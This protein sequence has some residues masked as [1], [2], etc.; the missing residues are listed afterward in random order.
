MDACFPCFGSRSKARDSEREPLLPKH[1]P[2]TDSEPTTSAAPNGTRAPQVPDAGDS[3]VINKVVEVLAALNAGKLPTQE[4]TTHLLQVLLGS[5]LLKEDNST[6]VVPGNGPTS[7]QG[8]KVLKDVRGLIQAMLQFGME[9][10]AD[11]KLQ[12]LYFQFLSLDQPPVSVSVHVDAGESVGK[13]QKAGEAA[14]DNSARAAAELKREAPTKNELA[15]DATTLFHA[16]RTIFETCLSSSVFRLVLS[17]II[18]I[19]RDLVAH[20]AAD[21]QRAAVEVQQVAED[22]EQN[23]LDQNAGDVTG[24]DKNGRSKMDIVSDAVNDVKEKG[25]EAAHKIKDTTKKE[26]NDVGND[27][28]DRT[29]ERMLERIR[30]TI[31]RIQQDPASRLAMRSILTLARKYAEKIASASETVSS[32]VEDTIEDAK[33]AATSESGATQEPNYPPHPYGHNSAS[34]SSTGEKKPF[35]DFQSDAILQDLKDILERIAKGHSLD[36][37]FDAFGRIVRGLNEMPT[38][39][40]KDVEK[41]TNPMTRSASSLISESGSD[42]HNQVP[43]PL[44]GKDPKSASGQEQGHKKRKNGKARKRQK[45]HEMKSSTSGL[46]PPSPISASNSQDST[47]TAST[48]K[49]EDKEREERLYSEENPLRTY[50]KRLG[51]YLDRAIEEKDW[52]ISKDGEQALESL[53][54][55]GAE[56]VNVVGDSVVQVED[57]M[58]SK[59]AE[60]EKKAVHEEPGS[61]EDKIKRQFKKDLSAF[62]DEAEAYIS[63]MENDKTTMKL[64]HAFENLGVDLRALVSKGAQQSKKSLMQ[65]LMDM[66]SWTNWVG[67]AI[68]RVLRMLPLSAIPIPSIEFKTPEVEGALQAIFVQGLAKGSER[69][70]E[71]MQY[72]SSN[73]VATSLVPDEVVLKQWTELRIDMVDYD[74]PL[75]GR[76]VGSA[77]SSSAVNASASGPAGPGVQTTSRFRM[78]LDGVRARVEGMGYYFKYKGDYLGYEDEG[79]ASV[80]LGMGQVHN[81]FAVDVEIEMSHENVAFAEQHGDADAGD[82]QQKRT[83]DTLVVEAEREVDLEANLPANLDVQTLLQRR[84]TGLGH[85]R[86]AIRDAVDAA[87]QPAPLFSV[88]D[89]DVEMRGLHFQFDKSRHWIL[90]KLFVQ[91]LAGPVVARV[92]KHAME[93]KI[94][95]SLE[96]LAVGLGEM[97]RDAARRAEKREKTSSPS[98]AEEGLSEILR[99]W[100][101]AML[102]VGPTLFGRS[103]VGGEEEEDERVEVVTRSNVQSTSKGLIYKNVTT[104]KTAEEVEPSGIPA[105]YFNPTTNTMEPVSLTMEDVDAEYQAPRVEVEEEETVVAVGGGAQLFPGKA[106]AYGVDH[107]ETDERTRLLDTVKQTAR[108][109]V[110]EAKD[111]VKRGVDVVEEAGKRWEERN[112]MEVKDNKKT[113]RSDAFNF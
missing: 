21:V 59:A 57:E 77:P 53:F 50:F 36:G 83:D 111:G 39:V 68:P 23:A 94:R 55:D 78:H 96:D 49:D 29:K 85:A 24:E 108:E 16:L 95:E 73:P 6:N 113:W 37:L 63:A 4:Q 81:G 71:Q 30:Q 8:R 110:E 25:K 91:P 19:A 112:K 52:A 75:R 2:N 26:F 20:A 31:S 27:A 86:D 51:E 101:G 106:G 34:G 47:M 65:S 54:V 89:V 33:Q 74:R 14:L 5:E 15:F 99:D 97:S 107:E 64:I 102:K 72:I 66:T 9:K 41:G 13:A 1:Q 28:T 67:W 35:I 32:K 18:S 103:S 79:I 93:K 58:I 48:M 61:K 98:S 38:V 11:D 62:M 60:G 12:E 69:T 45:A 22:V 7:R 100:W 82:Q 17:D 92:V 109:A 46:A 84:D 40:S 43:P 44:E 56:L 42:S 3:S 10:N 87:R 90:N 80:D 105:M 76:Y 88:V 70:Q 104:T